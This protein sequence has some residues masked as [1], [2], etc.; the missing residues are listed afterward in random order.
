MD[1]QSS[2]CSKEQQFSHQSEQPGTVASGRSCAFSDD[3]E[4]MEDEDSAHILAKVATVIYSHY[5]DGE[6]RF[7]AGGPSDDEFHEA[8]FV[9]RRRSC[10]CCCWPQRVQKQHTSRDMVVKLIADLVHSLFFCKQVVVLSL[11][12]IERFLERTRA[13][14]TPGNWRSLVI[15][16]I[17]VASKVGEDVHPWNADFEECLGDI[18][19]IWYQPGALYRLE[20]LFLERLNWRVFVRG[21]TYAAYYF[22]LLEDKELPSDPPLAEAGARLTR[23]QSEPDC[24]ATIEEVDEDA[25]EVA[26]WTS[27]GGNSSPRHLRLDNCSTVGSH[28]GGAGGLDALFSGEAGN[29][30]SSCNSVGSAGGSQRRGIP[31]EWLSGLPPGG[32]DG[33]VHGT[34]RSTH[35]GANDRLPG[36]DEVLTARR[37]HDVWVLDKAN[38][39]IGV[40][41]HAPRALAP[42]KMIAQ[43]NEKLWAHE[44][45]LRTSEK[46]MPRRDQATVTLSGATGTQL[47]SELRKYLDKGG[48]F[49]GVEEAPLG[50]ESQSKGKGLSASDGREGA[51]RV[52]GTAPE[53]APGLG[54]LFG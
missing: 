16:A 48:G 17:L 9:R 37:I 53:G 34:P 33:S 21:E 45:V 20:S 1:R 35:S 18:A 3:S 25:N 2:I 24:F 44:L 8:H 46:M 52:M 47:A 28:A 38:P 39:H 31:A 4:F 41:R 13:G 15:A 19:D 7:P 12:Y 23:S 10:W 42:S 11:V 51:S 50:L 40:L 26:F 29:L 54:S 32:A 49:K 22:A 36:K 5:E 43:S 27:G 6:S 14:V 30:R